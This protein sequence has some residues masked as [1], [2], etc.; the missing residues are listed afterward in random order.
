DKPCAEALYARSIGRRSF[1]MSQDS[2]GQWRWL[3]ACPTPY[4]LPEELIP[5]WAAAHGLDVEEIPTP[6]EMEEEQLGKWKNGING[7][8]T[9]PSHYVAFLDSIAPE[10]K[11]AWLESDF[12]QVADKTLDDFRI[13]TIDLDTGEIDDYLA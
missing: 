10:Y 8:I 5:A 12:Y 1:S 11:A 3:R 7:E 6:K 9:R 13:E 4:S 2:V